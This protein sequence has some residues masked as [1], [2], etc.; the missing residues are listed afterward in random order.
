MSF[1]YCNPCVFAIGNEYEILVLTNENGLVTVKVGDEIFY[2]ENS[3]AL[4]TEKNRA[5][6]RIP[7][8]VLDSAGK[9]SIS[10]RK[11][12]NRRAY[13]S[14]LGDEEEITYSFK[15]ITKTDG[16]NIYHISDVHYHFDIAKETASYF[17]SDLDLLVVNGDIGEVETVENYRE[18]AKFVGDLTNGE[19][20]S[21]FVR[22]NHDTR[23]HLAEIYTDYFPADGK[24]TYYTFDIGTL[25]GIVFD[26]GEDKVDNSIEYG[27]VNI[28]QSFRKQETEFL[29]SLVPSDK[30]TFAI[31]HICPAQPTGQKGGQFDIDGDVYE[32]WIT[33]FE[34]INIKFMLCG[35]IH[36]TYILKNNDTRSLRPHNFPVIVGAACYFERKDLWGTAI[37]LKD[38]K[39]TVLFTNPAHNVI[40]A[41][42]IDLK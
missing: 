25:H 24:K 38:G 36:R 23:G 40:E 2:E 1:L 3:G 22:G 13:Y 18:V 32:K 5:K 37:T 11:S 8:G 27:G 20:P 35:H 9:Y 39:A 42:E 21:V 34:R 10:F 17:G 4:S 12:I 19:I 41:H 33:E 7:M 29:K 6:I 28:F 14:Q 31:G 15:P 30:L 16:I 26:C